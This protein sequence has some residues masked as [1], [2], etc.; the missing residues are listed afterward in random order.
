MNGALIGAIVTLVVG[1]IMHTINSDD[2]FNEKLS[3]VFVWF[4]K[5]YNP[6]L[7]S[8]IPVNFKTFVPEE[9]HKIF[10]TMHTEYNKLGEKYLDNRGLNPL[11]DLRN[12]IK[13][14][15]M[16]EKYKQ[17]NVVHHYSPSYI[18]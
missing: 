5:N 17:P 9:L 14:D 6:D 16:K 4:I 12:K 1:V 10:D 13:Y 3:K 11:Y 18:E 15:V 8:N 7:N 2:A